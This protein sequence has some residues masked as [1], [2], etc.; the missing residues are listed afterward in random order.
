MAARVKRLCG[1]LKKETL[2]SR[3][4]DLK[5]K[6]KVLNFQLK[7]EP[8]R[9]KRDR[10]NQKFRTNQKDVFRSWQ[11]NEITVSNPPNKTET[12]K[13]WSEVWQNHTQTKM[14]SPWYGTVEEAYCTQATQK[15]YKISINDIK[16]AIMRMPNNK[17]PGTD[18]ITAV[19][20]K[21]FTC[22]HQPLLP[23]LQQL[24]SGSIPMPEWLATSRTTLIP[25]NEHTHQPNN[26]RPI[27]C[28]NTMYKLYTSILNTFLE[29][30]CL[31]NQV[32]THEQTG[33]RTERQ[34]GL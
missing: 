14:D 7:D 19:W 16:A 4:S 5:H 12:T 21:S 24:Y 34:L 11:G 33:R 6:L 8:T 13:F 15:E 28:L 29:D 27:A 23:L 2:E 17:A 31:T 32:I 26:F 30:H 20:L 9:S 10:I 1:N 3:L 18:Q 25:K 22:L